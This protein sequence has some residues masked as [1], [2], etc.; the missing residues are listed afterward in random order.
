MLTPRVNTTWS[1]F[2]LPEFD[3]DM[4]AS[5]CLG[6][7]RG[8]NKN[9]N[10]WWWRTESRGVIQR[11]SLLLEVHAVLYWC[12]GWCNVLSLQTFDAWPRSMLCLLFGYISPIPS[13]LSWFIEMSDCG[14][15]LHMSTVASEV[16]Y[17]HKLFGAKKEIQRKL[18]YRPKDKTTVSPL[19]A[20]S[21]S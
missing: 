15:A 1:F 20:W 8:S 3:P 2:S 7:R 10:N 17:C 14:D 12:Q 9:N 13:I 11:L 6:Y 5:S 19:E 4:L 21:H 18:K 16:T